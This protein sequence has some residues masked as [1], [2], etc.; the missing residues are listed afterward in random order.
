MCCAVRR[1]SIAVLLFFI[2]TQSMWFSQVVRGDQSPPE[3]DNGTQVGILNNADPLNE[4]S[5]L[6]A[7]RQNPNVLWTHEDDYDQYIFAMNTEGTIL[8]KYRVGTG[9]YDV[10][11][12]AIGPGPTEG[13]D[14]L[15]AGHIGD[16][17]AVRSNI[18]VRRV[19]EPAVGSTPWDGSTVTTLSGVSTITLQYL[20]GAKDAE[21]LMIDTNGDMYIVSKRSASNKVYRAAYPQSTTSTTI[22]ELVA[23]LP[24]D[25]EL[26]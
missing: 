17:D 23:T 25:P 10:E 8:G 13:V 2:I 14:Y 6:A 5:G 22:L 18:Y 24:A 15:Y 11:D 3:F 7:S 26:Y 4:A 21:S 19:P 20:D 12:I 9:G 1:I 16:N